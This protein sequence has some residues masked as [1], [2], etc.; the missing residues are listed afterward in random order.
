MIF[1]GLSKHGQPGQSMMI[2]QVFEDEEV[3]RVTWTFARKR[4]PRIG[5]PSDGSQHA[6]EANS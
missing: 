4:D 3:G 6:A 5:R 2:A 1:A